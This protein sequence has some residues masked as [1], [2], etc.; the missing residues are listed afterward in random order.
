MTINLSCTQDPAW[1]AEREIAWQKIEDNLARG[2]TKKEFLIRKNYFFDGIKP[3]TEM[4]P[5]GLLA[6][7][8]LCTEEAVRFVLHEYVDATK[9]GADQYFSLL[10]AFTLNLGYWPGAS[11]EQKVN[12]FQM[13]YGTSYQPNRKFPFLLGD[14]TTHRDIDYDANGQFSA[15]LRCYSR[16]PFFKPDDDELCWLDARMVDY[17]MSLLPY[18]GEELFIQETDIKA[19]KRQISGLAQRGY[20]SEMSEIMQ[21]IINPPEDVISAPSYKLAQPIWA[22]I[23]DYLD[24]VQTPKSL[25]E[26]WQWAK[27]EY[28]K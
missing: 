16:M 24:A 4:C 11:A 20:V 5:D 21:H 17:F 3:K 14:E 13:V 18:A 26:R 10:R 1:I 28:G 8:P 22:R 27:Q 6:Y 25:A 2:F 9:V 19:A 15:F 7:F 12:L 23:K